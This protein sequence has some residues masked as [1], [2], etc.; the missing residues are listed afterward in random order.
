MKEKIKI[1]LAAIIGAL[2]FWAMT[3]MFLIVT[4]G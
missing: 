1:A 2:Y 3:V 4:G